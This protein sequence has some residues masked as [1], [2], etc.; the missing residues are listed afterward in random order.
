MSRKSKRIVLTVAFVILAALLVFLIIRAHKPGNP[1]MDNPGFNTPHVT[2]DPNV[3]TVTFPEGLTVTEIAEKLEESK[4]CDK[5][6]FLNSVNNPSAELLSELGISNRY[7]RVFTLEGY[8]FPDT[9]EF[10]KGESPASVLQRFI[11]NYRSKITENDKLRAS[12]L[13]YTMDEILTIAS[14]IQEEAGRPDQDYK[15]SSV[16]HNRLNSG[17]KIECDVTITYLED[18]CAPYLPF[19][20]TEANKENYNTYKCPALPKGPI[21]NPGYAAIQAALYPEQTSYLF[22]VTDKDMNYYYA[23]TWDEHVANCR[24]AEIPGY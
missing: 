12:E 4:V 7:E 2:E 22:F 1:T 3:A 8:V 5:D 17:T 24:T 13:G 10:Y 11:D 19:G 21:C 20:L 23:A 9:Y 16:L 6:E 18:H 14:I 15:V